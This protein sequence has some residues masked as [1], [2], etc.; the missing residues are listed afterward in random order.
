MLRSA[1]TFAASVLLACSVAACGD[2]GNEGETPTEVAPTQEAPSPPPPSPS[3]PTTP[4]ADCGDIAESGAGVY[5]VQAS[6][7]DCVMA[8]RIASEWQDQCGFQGMTDCPVAGYN[9]AGDQ[10]GSE[11]FKIVCAAARAEGGKV[12]FT[13][14]S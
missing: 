6:G 9:C 7:V 11:L 1:L 5:G 2:E 14:G 10:Q 12:R 13:F 4:F 8:D 3:E